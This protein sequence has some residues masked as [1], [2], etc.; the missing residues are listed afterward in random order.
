MSSKPSETTKIIP[1][2]SSKE[3]PD[4]KAPFKYIFQTV[5]DQ[6]L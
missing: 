3:I 5:D 2:S 1:E 4:D 6:P